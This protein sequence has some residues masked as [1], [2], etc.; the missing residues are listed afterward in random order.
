MLSYVSCAQ[1]FQI[2]LCSG[3][4][5]KRVDTGVGSIEERCAN[6][7]R[8]ERACCAASTQSMPAP[9][10]GAPSVRIITSRASPRRS[11]SFR[12]RGG[13]GDESQMTSSNR[14]P[15]FHRRGGD[16]VWQHWLLTRAPWEAAARAA[17]A[18]YD[19]PRV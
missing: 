18:N 16:T 6:G 8:E 5:K 10:A 14:A 11:W 1:L 9:S 13:A 7:V 12:P 2:D 4:R 3:R 15:K 17:V 19:G